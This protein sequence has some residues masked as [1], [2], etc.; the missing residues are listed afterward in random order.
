M[1]N[2]G[3]NLETKFLQVTPFSEQTINDRINE[4]SEINCKLNVEGYPIKGSG[5]I[6]TT[7]EK[8]FA[9]NFLYTNNIPINS[10]SYNAT[11]KRILNNYLLINEQNSKQ[12]KLKKSLKF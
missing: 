4:Y 2:I 11:I 12:L 9:F 8:I 6:I 10:K 5:R 1:S 7:D 3:Y